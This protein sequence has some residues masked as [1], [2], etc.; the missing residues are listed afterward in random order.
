MSAKK[1]IE[2]TNSKGILSDAGRYGD[3]YAHNVIA[4]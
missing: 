2:E 1:W 4:L 3:T